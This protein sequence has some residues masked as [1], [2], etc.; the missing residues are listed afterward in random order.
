[1]WQGFNQLGEPLLEA[2]T[3][4]NARYDFPQFI[5]CMRELGWEELGA[6]LYGSDHALRLYRKV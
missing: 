2:V 3:H 6:E 4:I 1:M 5:Q